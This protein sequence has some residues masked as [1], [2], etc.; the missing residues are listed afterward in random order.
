MGD[1]WISF[2]PWPRN[3]TSFEIETAKWPLFNPHN[4]SAYVYFPHQLWKQFEKF[5]DRLLNIGG[6]S[7]RQLYFNMI[8]V[9]KAPTPLNTL[10][11]LLKE[12]E[13]NHGKVLYCCDTVK[14]Y[15]ESSVLSYQNKLAMIA[16]HVQV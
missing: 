10:A 7:M 3:K 11:Q 12:T 14:N 9:S 5:N 15:F 16:V 8:L 6:N 4:H 13:Y 2:N 1:I